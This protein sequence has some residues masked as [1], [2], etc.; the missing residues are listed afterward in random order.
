MSVVEAALLGPGDNGW[1]GV[2][3]T[4]RVP[5]GIR[6][7]APLPVRSPEPPLR[8]VGRGRKLGCGTAAAIALTFFAEAQR[9]RSRLRV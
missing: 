5:S 9:R 3:P 1:G 6:V 8:K 4:I 7:R 2:W